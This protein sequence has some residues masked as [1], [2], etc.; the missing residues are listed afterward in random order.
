MNAYKIH[1][2]R[3]VEYYN[4]LVFLKAKKEVLSPYVIKTIIDGNN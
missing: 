2:D 4:W 3:D 1:N